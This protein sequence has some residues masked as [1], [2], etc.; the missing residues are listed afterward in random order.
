VWFER[1]PL[2]GLPPEAVERWEELAARAVEP[3]PFLESLF[4]LPALEHRGGEG[5]ELLVA[6][7]GGHWHACLP[8]RPKRRWQAI[9]LP[10]LSTWSHRYCFLDSPL[11]AHE[12]AAEALTALLR[13]AFQSR[14]VAFLVFSEFGLVGPV[15]LALRQA[16]KALG[17]EVMLY[18]R[19]TRALLRRRAEPD[20]FEKLSANRRKNLSRERRSLER[21]LGSPVATVDR[22]LDPEA[23]GRFLALEASGWKGR[24]GTAMA[25]DPRDSAF[26][27]DLCARLASAERLQLL[28]LEANDGEASGEPLAMQVNL[29]AGD[30]LFTFKIAY[31]ERFRRYSPGVQLDL[32]APDF[33][34]RD[35]RLAWAD[36]CM[37][38]ESELMNVLWGDR[39]AIATIVIP[40]P[41]GLGRVARPFVPASRW[42]QGTRTRA[43]DRLSAKLMRRQST[44]E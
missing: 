19:W 41:T 9:P 4:A 23:P 31:D 13:G 12:D 11:V 5:V 33:F 24:E 35:R 29:C 2:R 8:V 6:G 26:F 43:R 44:T 14:R 38:A 21:E 27:L 20:Y 37:P 28:S 32:D 34:D 36:S 1:Y 25:S 17:T 30:G 39:R 18:E 15:E 10:C 22:S 40:A 3:N 7:E 16:C 42:I